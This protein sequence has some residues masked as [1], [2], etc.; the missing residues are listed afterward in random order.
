MKPELRG[1][2]AVWKRQNPLNGKIEMVYA[3]LVE[4]N[5][6]EEFNEVTRDF[7]SL[8]PTT[9]PDDLLKGYEWEYINQNST[10]TEYEPF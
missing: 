4:E 7:F 5:P 1:V 3:R 9:I 8:E 2:T 10:T 6:V